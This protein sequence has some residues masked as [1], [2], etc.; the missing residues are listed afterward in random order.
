MRRASSLLGPFI[1]RKQ[2]DRVKP[3]VSPEQDAGSQYDPLVDG[4]RRIGK[5][6]A[7]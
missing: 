6:A 2:E 4:G 7:S 3:T 1:M 5:D